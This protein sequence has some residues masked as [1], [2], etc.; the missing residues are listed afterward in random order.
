MALPFGMTLTRAAKAPGRLLPSLGYLALG[1]LLSTVLPLLLVAQVEDVARSAAWPATLLLS[2]WAGIRLTIIIA[3]GRPTLF[4]FFFWLFVYI[5]MGIG[6][7]VQMRSDLIAGTT[8]GI[9]PALDVP[10]ATLVWVGVGCYEVGRLLAAR[11]SHW[12][13]RRLTGGQR[14]PVHARTEPEG[15]PVTGVR[16]T[17]TFA[18][19]AV[20]SLASVWFVYNVGLGALFGSREERSV[21]GNLAWPDPAVRSI[22]GAIATY[23]LLIGI[24]ALAQLRRRVPPRLGRRYLVLMVCATTL[25]LLVVNPLSSARYSLGTVLFALSVFAG[26]LATSRRVRGMLLATI[27]GFIFLFPLADAFRRPEIDF[28]R[29][30][31]FGEYKGNPDYDAFWQIANSYSYVVDGLVEPGRQALGVVFFW[32][33]RSFWSDKPVDTGILLANYRGYS[34]DNLSGPLWAEL[35]VNGGV[36]ALVVGFLVFGFVLRK[37]DVLLVPAFAAA[38]FW[39]IVGAVFPVYMTIL[40]R[41]SLLQATGVLA[42]ATVCL[43]LVR[44]ARDP[45]IAAPRTMTDT[46]SPAPPRLLPY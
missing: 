18:I 42:V 31:F 19:L 26:A 35:L 1:A 15:G 16:A 41:G 4:D 27:G 44:D 13:R 43:L 12:S 21:A 32:V 46:P 29:D 24:G 39:A 17:T 3:Q 36:V 22:M 33:P 10:T 45:L 8:K 7:T 2:V 25:L 38:G 34:F 23:P 40:L 30:G 9:D 5:F 6:P 28:A 14:A 20:G 37:M 11:R